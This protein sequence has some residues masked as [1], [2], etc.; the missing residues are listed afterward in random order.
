MF[1][2]ISVGLN[3]AAQRLA[4]SALILLSSHL[5]LAGD[6]KKED[7]ER[8][9]GRPYQVQE[10]LTEI[11][12]WP[13]TSALEQEA[14]PVGYVFESIDLA[15]LPGF[16]GTPMNFL[17]S[18][19]RKGNFIDVEL[20]RQ[21]E[22]VFT[23]RDLGGLGDTPLREFI[24]QYIG[25]NIH[26]PFLIAMDAARNRTGHASNNGIA[27]LDGIS[28]ATTSIRIVNQAVLSAASEVA[29]AKLGFADRKKHGPS[30]Q[31]RPDV[32]DPVGF[33]EMLRKGMVGRV[34]VTH[35]EVEKLFAG[36]EGANVD[37]TALAHPDEVFVD[38]YVA[39]LNAPT[40]GRA[41]LGDAQY[42]AVMERNFDKRHLWW[43]A[44]AG[45]YSILDDNFIPGAPSPRLAMS[46]NGMFYDLRDEDFE[47]HDIAGPPE[48]NASRLFGV[49]AA[50]SL[51]PASPVELM[52]TVSRAKGTVLPTVI[53]RQLALSYVPPANLFAY[54]PEPLPEWLLAWKNRW[55]DLTVLAASLI[56]LSIVLA[57]PRWISLDKR[58][59]RLFRLGFLAYTLLY[60]GWYAQ[61]QLS[62]V[63]I[64][65]A[66][67]TLKAGLGLASYLY[68]PISLLLIAFTVISFVF[69]GRGTFCGWLCPFGALQE[70]VGR[71]ARRLGVPRLRIPPSVARR[72]EFGR[73]L[74]LA[75]LLGAAFW[76]PTEGETLNE[77]EPFKTVITLGF[78]RTWPFIAY[79]AVLLVAGTFYY[80]FF[81]RFLCPL[82]GA[83]S[84]GGLLRRFDWLNRRAECGK[85]C[86]RCKAVCDYDAIEPSG[87]IRYEACFQC[88]DCVGIYHDDKRC[89][90]IMLYQKK[91]KRLRPELALTQRAQAGG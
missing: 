63:Q 22:P 37:E 41:I 19:D 48:L 2:G 66:I 73:Y 18:I 1:H 53:T 40:I 79:A 91:G 83:M 38:L 29:R 49:N 45:R 16:E 88:L 76:L 3:R 52:L 50:A 59:L 14:G 43:I 70:F 13:L 4:I 26:Q 80:K 75:G 78:D 90:P 9:F 69:W 33:A 15:P 39:Y 57:R 30:A 89:V 20:L 67:K 34:R 31:V 8:R 44:S 58:R 74:I 47:P 17:V 5:T 46:Q 21:R 56:V 24:A 10:K 84:L 6:L 64:T 72:L 36:T 54:P 60:I 28:K 7:I 82:G 65:G 25:R 12:A 77:V 81:C 27:T 55:V 42:A 32:Y 86:Q 35:A 85:P 87:E 11:P 23:F 68:D 61:G 71:L 51:D 62:I